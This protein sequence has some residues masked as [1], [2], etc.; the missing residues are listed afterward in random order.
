MQLS[1]YGIAALCLLVA[2]CLD[3]ESPAS[4]RTSASRPDSTTLFEDERAEIDPGV[5]GWA[6][7]KFELY[8]TARVDWE[9]F[10][11]TGNGVNVCIIPNAEARSWENGEAVR[12]WTC[13]E[14]VTQYSDHV[15][16]AAGDYAIAFRTEHGEG[17][18]V[19]YSVW[20][21]A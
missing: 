15:T 17:A 19:T 7:H 14:R 6:A 13:H 11:R 12:G 16:L 21:K 5:G 2:G 1:R 10:E 18:T 3:A 8:A 20:A 9:I 4:E